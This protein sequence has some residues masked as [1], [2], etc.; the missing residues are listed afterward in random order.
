MPTPGLLLVAAL[1]APAAPAVG[2][3]RLSRGLELVYRGEVVE[4]SDRVENRF[5]KMSDLEIRVLVLEAGPRAADCAV[6]TRV[7]PRED[8]VVAGAAAAVT[9]RDPG[10]TPSPPAVSLEFVR[11]DARGRCHILRP[12]PGP[13][14]VPLGPDVPTTPAPAVPVDGP[15]QIELGL[16][17]PLPPAV[18]NV[19]DGWDVPDPGRPPVVWAAAGEAVWNGGRCVELTGVQQSDGWDRSAAVPT[20]W[21]RTETVLTSPADGFAASVRRR[22]E[23]RDGADVT[24]WVEV[25]YE[26]SPPTRLLGSRYTDA[27]AEAD[28]GYCF[29]ASPGPTTLAKIDRYVADHPTPTAYRDAV[30]AARRR[31]LSVARGDAV[32][33]AAAVVPVEAVEV[34]KPAPDFVAAGRGGN[35]RLSA[36]RGKPVVLVFVKPGAETTPG[37]L[38]VAEALNQ[39]F[40]DRAVVVAVGAAEGSS[41]PVVDGAGVRERY[42]VDAYPRFVVVDAAGGVAWR[43]DGFGDET[44]YL[45]KQE[46][47]R[48]L[49]GG[50]ENRR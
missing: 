26:L 2:P 38:A 32:L 44:G 19:G 29:A 42:G 13:P 15:P 37:A 49:S 20:G 18:V 48:L 23:R 24:G 46:V 10:R 27:R 22:C 8:P 39:R 30:D 25:R 1:L 35:F 6:L 36:H 7:R 40:A 9:G 50:S 4:A 45:A 43:F 5:R 11:V 41:V 28:A 31:C 17:V 3:P 47:E 12:P 21:R 14:P 33:P 34:G 16:F